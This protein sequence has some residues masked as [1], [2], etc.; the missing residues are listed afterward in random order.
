[1]DAFGPL[2]AARVRPSDISDTRGAR[3]LL[4]G[5]ALL[6]PRLE[7]VWAD[8]AWAGGNLGRWCEEHAGWLLRIAP[9]NVGRMTFEVLPRRWQSAASR[10][11]AAT[12]VW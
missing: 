5:L 8:G 6:M 10:G 4:A 3:G 1:M 7:V 9:R 2:L 12:G 11:S